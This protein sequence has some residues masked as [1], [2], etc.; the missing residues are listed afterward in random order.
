MDWMS[1]DSLECTP[2]I[3]NNRWFGACFLRLIFGLEDL[4]V[5]VHTYTFKNI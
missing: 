2:L 4:I 1:L 3:I 5:V